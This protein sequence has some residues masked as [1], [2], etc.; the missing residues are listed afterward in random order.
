MLRE[1]GLQVGDVLVRRMS[2]FVLAVSLL[3]GGCATPPE[4]VD[5]GVLADVGRIG[6]VVRQGRHEDLSGTETIVTDLFVVQVGGRT[7]E[8]SLRKAVANLHSRN[9]V[10]SVDGS[11]LNVWLKSPKWKGATLAVYAF[12]VSE[13]QDDPEVKKVMEGQGLSPAEVVE[14]AA[15]V[16]W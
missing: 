3:A 13:Q 1:G 2:A 5:P 8:E 12:G 4:L 16:G 14:V 11:P 7:E 15:Y 6:K 10:T 9:W